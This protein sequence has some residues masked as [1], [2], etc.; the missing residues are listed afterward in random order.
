M[1]WYRT[2]IAAGLLTMVVMIA[3][4]SAIVVAAPQIGQP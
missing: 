1:R 4:G 3:L 2:L